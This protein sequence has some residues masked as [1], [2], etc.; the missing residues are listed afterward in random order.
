MKHK[1]V[2]L[3]LAAITMLTAALN[4]LI[5]MAGYSFWLSIALYTLSFLVATFA[6]LFII[7]IGDSFMRRQRKIKRLFKN[8]KAESDK[9][10]TLKKQLKGITDWNLAHRKVDWVLVQEEIESIKENINSSILYEQGLIE[11]KQAAIE[12]YKQL[13]VE[14]EGVK[15]HGEDIKET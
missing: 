8:D 3:S 13:L 4:I 12:G 7:S 10:D 6:A 1:E 11:T 14:L 2:W 9:R 15:S 5:A